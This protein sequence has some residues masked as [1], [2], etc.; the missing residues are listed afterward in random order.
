MD[1]RVKRLGGT[2]SIDSTP[3]AGTTIRAELPLH[4][5]KSGRDA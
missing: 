1:E 3:G 4:G 5:A 2:L